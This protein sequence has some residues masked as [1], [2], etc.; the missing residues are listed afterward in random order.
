M[1]PIGDQR[2]H[3]GKHGCLLIIFC[4]LSE[5]PIYVRQ[6]KNRAQEQEITIGFLKETLERVRTEV[7]FRHI[8][9]LLCC[10]FLVVA[11]LSVYVL[12]CEPHTS[13]PCSN[14]TLLPSH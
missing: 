3:I 8:P 12:R 9:A 10:I 11:E 7:R 1:K 14:C 6:L 2:K 5:A 4:Q 13:L